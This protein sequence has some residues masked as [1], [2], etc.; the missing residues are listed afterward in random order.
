MQLNPFLY[1]GP[2]STIKQGLRSFYL[3]ILRVYGGYLGG[4]GRGFKV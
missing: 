2:P 3:G 1:L 4:L